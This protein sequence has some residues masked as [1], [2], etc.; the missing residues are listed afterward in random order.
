MTWVSHCV[1]AINTTTVMS[2][3]KIYGEMRHE[4]GGDSSLTTRLLREFN[5]ELHIDQML[6]RDSSLL[7]GEPIIESLDTSIRP[8][9]MV[10]EAIMSS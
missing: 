10:F 6:I 3:L 7:D 2:T 4:N 9:W 5:I 8:F 1:K